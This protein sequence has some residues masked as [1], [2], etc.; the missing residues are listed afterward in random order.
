MWQ[1]SGRTRASRWHIWA[2][3]GGALTI[4]NRS[5]TQVNTAPLYLD[6]AD[7]LELPAILRDYRAVIA[8]D[9]VELQTRAWRG[10]SSGGGGCGVGGAL[11]LLLGILATRGLWRRTR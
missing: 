1:A 7:A 2:G 6:G 5:S 8:G 11:A 3:N 10:V 9:R 4:A